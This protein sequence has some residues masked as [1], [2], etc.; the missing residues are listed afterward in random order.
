MG[1]MDHHEDDGTH[2]L[3][4]HGVTASCAD[5]GGQRV[6]VPVDDPGSGAYCCTSCDAAVFLVAVGAAPWLSLPPGRVA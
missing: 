1:C 5:C 4:L 3:M 2:L 6:F